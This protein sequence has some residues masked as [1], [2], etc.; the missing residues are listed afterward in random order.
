MSK[1]PTIIIASFSSLLII[2]AS[3]NKT[4]AFNL[5]ILILK[6]YQLLMLFWINAMAYDHKILPMSI[7]SN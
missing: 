3:K 2:V 6:L 1:Y 5:T 7:S 4:N